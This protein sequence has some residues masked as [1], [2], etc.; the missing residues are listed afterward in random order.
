MHL[1]LEFLACDPSISTMNHSKL[2]VLNQMEE[3]IS[4][5]RVVIFQDQYT[6][7]SLNVLYEYLSD[8]A[9][10]PLEREFVEI[11]DPYCSKVNT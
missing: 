8:S 3:S 1:H 6:Y 2:I 10:S 9:I 5:A 11:E 4:I 7:N